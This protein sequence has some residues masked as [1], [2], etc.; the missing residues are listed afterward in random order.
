MSFKYLFFLF[1]PVLLFSQNTVSI[2]IV[3]ENKLAVSRAI[4]IVSQED[5]QIAFGTTNSEGVFDKVLPSGSYVFNIKKLGFTPVME[6]VLVQEKVSLSFVLL[7]ETN[8]L[9][10][11][12][13]TSRPK[14]MRIKGDTISYNLKA[15]VDGTENKIEDVIKKLPG[16]DVDQDGKV[17]YKGQQ[18]NNVLID[19]NEFFG[20]KHQMA[21][22]N[23]SA[24]MI[25]GVD[26]LT[27]YSG[28]SLAAG[29]NNGV[30]LNL[31]TKDAYKNKWVSDV[32]L[33]YGVNNALRFHSNSFKFFKKGNLAILTDYNTIAKTPISREDYREMRVASNIDSE[34]NQSKEVEIPSFLN[35][36]SFIKEKKNAFIGVT[37][38]SLISPRA[39]ITFSHIF[40]KTNLMEENNKTQ[41][42]IGDSDKRISFLENKNGSY[43]LNNSSIKWEFNKSKT[44][45]LSYVA[46]LTPN[47]DDDNQELLRDVNEINY[48]KSNTNLS[49]AQVFRLQTL[50][51]KTINYKILVKQ[52]SDLNEQSLD[53]FSQNILFDSGYDML[54]Q[55]SKNQDRSFGFC[56][57]FSLSKKSNIFTLKLNLLTHNTSINNNIFQN[58]AYNANFELKN[59]SL[60]SK[61]SWLKNWSPKLQSLFGLNITNSNN[62]FQESE[63]R[64]TRYEPNMSLIYSFS[65]FNKL[66]F[67]YVLD[68]QLLTLS[69][70]QDFSMIF[71]FQTIFR[72]SLVDF[73]RIVPKN[74]YSL[75]YFS[76]NPKN[77][78]VLFSSLVYT[79]ELNSISNNTSYASDY[80]ESQMINSQGT[81]SLRA[82]VA[83]DMKFKRLPF[84]V[85][86]TLFY[87]NATGN[88]Q[89]NGIDNVFSSSNFTSKTKVISN[90]KKS[91]VQFGVDYNYIQR[92][93][94]QKGNNTKHMYY[95][96]QIL[97][98][99]T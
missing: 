67:N 64:F 60:E 88:S 32:E 52:S 22:Q 94:E 48:V 41:T 45:F 70:I 87:L 40:N 78:N 55:Q 23:I 6:V 39:K 59:Q 36:N 71:D 90:F 91:D 49:F 77:N 30:A 20:N 42:N 85:K 17:L 43:V 68:H 58:P 31:K 61:L 25:E 34:D 83:Y 89:F 62:T 28:F 57:F 65:G 46:G 3:D 19:G 27:N 9:Q 29:G 56:N 24:E 63:N 82:L 75:Q 66:T 80:I 93:I 72:P 98:K 18:I 2:K 86:T 76:V 14:T 44:T 4:V 12:V 26:L 79:K 97:S 53:L 7:P 74:S 13:I 84:S 11:V 10:N 15:I 38:T 50:L 37:Y 92:S 96:A 1:F 54:F 47:S 16:L 95:M 21:T 35:P 99:N 5:N 69:Q 33:G 8:Q 73:S 51:L 81:T